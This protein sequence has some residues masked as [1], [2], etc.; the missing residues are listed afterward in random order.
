MFIVLLIFLT[1]MISYLIHAIYVA[2]LKAN[3]TL[4]IDNLKDENS[5]LEKN[6]QSLKLKEDFYSNIYDQLERKNA[7]IAKLTNE[8]MELKNK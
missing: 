5:L 4:Q 6:V 8:I 1:A 2:K 3:F 7:E